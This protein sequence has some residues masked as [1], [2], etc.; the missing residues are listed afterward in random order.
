MGTS[1]RHSVAIGLCWLTLMSVPLGVRAT[2]PLSTPS[3]LDITVVVSDRPDPRDAKLAESSSG[4]GTHT[5]RRVVTA[6]PVQALTTIEDVSAFKPTKVVPAAGTSSED[7]LPLDAPENNISDEQLEWI[8][9]EI[10]ASLKQ[11]SDDTNRMNQRET[12]LRGVDPGVIERGRQAFD[13][14]C[15]E[16]H[17]ADRALSRTKTRAA[18]FA[19]VR[20]MATKDGA[21]IS[22][23]D[24]EPI[25]SYLASRSTASGD[26]A[27]Q[28]GD[29]ATG[30][31]GES[32]SLFATI[33]PVW[34]GT[35]EEVENKGF[36]PDVWIGA[37]WQPAGPISG[38]VTA[39]T[40]C[41]GENQGLGVEL[42]EANVRLDLVQLLTGCDRSQ[43]ADHALEATV[44][45]GRFVVPFGAFAAKS[46]PGAYRTIS[47]PLMF[48]MGRRVGPTAFRQPVIPMPYADE[49]VDLRLKRKVWKDIT[50]TFDGYAVNGLQMGG[51]TVFLSSRSYRDNN[52]KLGV[53]GRGTVG[54]QFFEVG[55]S[56]MSG[57]MQ[58]DGSP[59]QNYRLFGGD[60]TLRYEDFVRAYFEYAVRRED[61]FAGFDSRAQ[62]TV[63]EGEVRVWNKPG[64]GLLARYDTLKHR[65]ALGEDSTYRFTSG[66]NI[67]LPGGSL[68]LINHERWVFA[69]GHDV[70]ILGL[71]W[72]TVF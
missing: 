64:I 26:D 24:I 18:W 60:I 38:G 59:L 58:P 20:R 48:I 44:K 41:H 55:G 70:N 54:N 8:R 51:P 13:R 53:G 67:T 4:A 61:S 31:G 3:P 33:S 40:S 68:F 14:S 39:C 72:T 47:K 6:S 23:G 34:R 22:A 36:F 35:D 2:E 37:D 49:G 5:G 32:L 11:D 52:S 56:I 16:C 62:G 25:V 71:R 27:S 63:V 50:A 19:T 66:L 17:E 43:R 42:V 57:E 46:S 15:T 69:D 9:Q 12:G 29:G 28:S 7:S 45:A 1:Q 30:S 21:D 10:L 65:G